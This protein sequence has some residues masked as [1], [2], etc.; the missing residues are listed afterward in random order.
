MDDFDELKILQALLMMFG[1]NA[2]NGRQKCTQIDVSKCE[3]A[4][5]MV[6][7]NGNERIEYHPRLFPHASSQ[8]IED[9]TGADRSRQIREQ[10]VGHQDHRLITTNIPTPNVR[11]LWQKS[12]HRPRVS[13]IYLS[14]IPLSRHVHEYEIRLNNWLSG[15]H[16]DGKRVTFSRTNTVVSPRTQNVDIVDST[17]STVA[18][19]LDRGF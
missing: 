12:T 11:I 14:R 7:N 4:R 10:L 16:G 2:S 3:L 5:R 18:Q 15:G 1:W 13:S 9:H 19:E 17:S 6:N 8:V